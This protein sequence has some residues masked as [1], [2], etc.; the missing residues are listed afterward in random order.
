MT[1][2][3]QDEFVDLDVS[4]KKTI[5]RLRI[6]SR[7]SAVDREDRIGKVPVL[8]IA[9]YDVTR[10]RR[11]QSI[12]LAASVFKLSDPG[13]LSKIKVQQWSWRDVCRTRVETPDEGSRE[14]E[15]A[16]V[17]GEDRLIVEDEDASKNVGNV[18]R[19]REDTVCVKN[20]ESTCRSLGRCPPVLGMVALRGVLAL[21]APWGLLVGSRVAAPGCAA[22]SVSHFAPLPRGPLTVLRSPPSPPVARSESTCAEERLPCWQSG[23]GDG[24]HQ[25]RGLSLRGLKPPYTRRRLKS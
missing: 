23:S 6:I 9:K 24:A 11:M 5:T 7:R 2:K 13:S 16:D 14:Q 3:N 25:T 22:C 8:G 12:N 18:S 17:V 10:F 21:S 4:I 20:V 1:L 15:T 19:E